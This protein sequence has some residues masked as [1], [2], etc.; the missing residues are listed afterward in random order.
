M[1][2]RLRS[3]HFSCDKRQS[4]NMTDPFTVKPV[5][6]M[7]SQYIGNRADIGAG[8]AMRDGVLEPSNPFERKAARPP[9]R[10]FVLFSLVSA[11]VFGCFSHFNNLL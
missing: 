7:L 1:D 10:W 3:P 6:S 11:L 9:R 8:K 4:E 2:H 5:Y